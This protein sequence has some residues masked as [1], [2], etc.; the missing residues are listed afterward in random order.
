MREGTVMT[1]FHPT[2]QAEPSVVHLQTPDKAHVTLFIEAL[3]GRVKV[4]YG[5]AEREKG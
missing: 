5:Y 1:H 3:A 4:V 2:G